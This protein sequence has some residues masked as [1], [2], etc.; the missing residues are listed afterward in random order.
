MLFKLIKRKINALEI[1]YSRRPVNK[2]IG[3]HR[4]DTVKVEQYG[5]LERSRDNETRCK[6]GAQASTSIRH[7]DRVR[8]LQGNLQR[9]RFLFQSAK[10]VSSYSMEASSSGTLYWSRPG[11]GPNIHLVLRDNR[12]LELTYFLPTTRL[13]CH[14]NSTRTDSRCATCTR[15]LSHCSNFCY[16]QFSGTAYSTTTELLANG[17]KGSN[18]IMCFLFIFL[19]WQLMMHE[20]NDLLRY[21]KI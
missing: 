18:F 5:R 3:V 8:N 16:N 15:K 20:K 13:Q 9:Y 1:N 17:W 7:F 14:E 10:G 2:H 12:V 11:H 19:T 21:L 6:I 4:C